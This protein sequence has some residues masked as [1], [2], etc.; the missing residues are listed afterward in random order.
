MEKKVECHNEMVKYINKVT[1]LVIEH[2]S[3]NPPRFKVDGELYK[4]N[5]DEVMKVIRS[6]E[7]PIKVQIYMKVSDFSTNY[8][9]LKFK[10]SYQVSE[11]SCAYIEKSACVWSNDTLS[12]FVPYEEHSVGEVE[13]VVNHIGTLKQQV[14]ALNDEI[15]KLRFS[16]YP[17]V[18]R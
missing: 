18:E 7:K 8:I 5:F 10:S 13:N 9:D 14:E 17:L 11:H 16:V 4:K 15:N 3:A 2:F 1:P 12:D 6:V